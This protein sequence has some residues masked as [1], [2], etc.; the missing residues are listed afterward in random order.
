M[1]DRKLPMLGAKDQD[2]R[3]LSGASGRTRL[4]VGAKLC[5]VS[6]ELVTAAR[7]GVVYPQ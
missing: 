7:C 5:K 3:E 1:S 6:T 2:G 4:K